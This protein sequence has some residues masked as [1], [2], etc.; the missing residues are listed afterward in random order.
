TDVVGPEV[1]MQADGSLVERIRNA[2]DGVVALLQID[3]ADGSPLDSALGH[4]PDPLPR[5]RSVE[6][7]EVFQAQRTLVHGE[8]AELVRVVVDGA[9]RPGFPTEREQL[10]EIVAIDQVAGV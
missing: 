8:P 10:E 9:R 5:S 6:G 7:M 3:T 2:V 1:H 4:Q